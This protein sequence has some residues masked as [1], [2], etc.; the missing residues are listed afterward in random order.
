MLQR[1]TEKKNNKKK[2]KK[3]K[4]MMMIRE[5]EADKDL[6]IYAYKLHDRMRRLDSLFVL[7]RQAFWAGRFFG[8]EGC[9][10]QH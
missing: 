4:V 3:K 5:G 9:L 2:K 7:G 10:G 1:L 8:P 6:L